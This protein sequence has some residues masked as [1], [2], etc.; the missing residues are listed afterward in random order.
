VEVNNGENTER[1]N[2]MNG[3]SGTHNKG[4]SSGSKMHNEKIIKGGKLAARGSQVFKNKNGNS[5]KIGSDNLQEVLR[6]KEIS[7]GFEAQI[8]R[9]N[10]NNSM[11][12]AWPQTSNNME[13]QREIMEG[14]NKSGYEHQYGPND[15]DNTKYAKTS[16]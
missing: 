11:D 3:N 5:L 4:K 15:S 10:N 6:E 2:N 7:N 14:T 9:P 1:G 16:K 13:M 12:F 8:Q